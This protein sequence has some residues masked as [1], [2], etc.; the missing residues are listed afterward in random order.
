MIQTVE[1]LAES[2]AALPTDERERFYRLL[3]S[4]LKNGG[5]D[6]EHELSD[7]NFRKALKWVDEHR[8]EYDGQFVLL[9][10]GEMI[11]HGTDPKLL[12][13]E[14]RRLGIRAPFVKRVKAVVLPFGGW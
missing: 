9:E 10:G 12:Y 2:V 14:A 1:K 8:K 5:A 11:A 6:Q 3:N 7:E 4:S 13:E